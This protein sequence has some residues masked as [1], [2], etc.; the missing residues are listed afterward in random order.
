NDPAILLIMGLG[1]Q[2]TSWP[3]I[4]CQGLVEQ[5]FF[6]IRFDNR[7]CG[8]SSK[9]DHLGKPNF[10]LNQIRSMLRLPVRAGYTLI[11]MA[12]DSIAVLDAVGVKQAHIVGA[13]M[14]GMIAQIVASNYPERALSLTSIMS[15]SG[16]RGLPGPTVAARRAILSRP[17]QPNNIDQVVQHFA[18]VYRAIG[19]PAYPTPEDVLRKRVAASIKRSVCPAGVLRQIAAI[20]A[21]GNRVKLLQALRTPTLVIHGTADPLVPIACGRDT[22]RLVPGAVMREIVGMGHDFPAQLN[23]TLMRMIGAHCKTQSV[24]DSV[25]S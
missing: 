3:E 17:A 25:V 24:P 20:V 4:F 2:L 22:A 16:R 10:V 11:D 1:M 6:V 8:L 12:R 9:L 5:G 19:S 15:T 23:E 21:S 14:G 18:G 7:D 13:S